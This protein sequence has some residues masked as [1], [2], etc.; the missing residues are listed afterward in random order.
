MS[1]PDPTRPAA[2]PRA[3]AFAPGDRF[4][5][6]EVR[7]FLGEGGSGEVY[8][9]ENPHLG[10]AYAL[11]IMRLA[12]REDPRKVARALVEGKGASTVEHANV[13]RVFDLGCEPDGRVWI[14]M[15]RLEGE[16]L[17]ERLA[18]QQRL[19]PL[20]ALRV[21]IDAAWGLDAAHE[22]QILHRD[23]KPDN[24]FLTRAG[25]VK[26]LDFSIAKVIPEG[27]QTTLGKVGLG[28][29]GYMA[30]ERFRGAR[31]DARLDV[32]A[33]GITLWQ[34]LAGRHPFHEALGDL[35]AMIEKQLRVLPAPLAGELGLPAYVDEVIA[36]AVAKDPAARFL[37]MA[38]MAQALLGVRERLARDA[39]EKR[40]VLP[41]PPEGE[42]KL[43]DDAPTQRAYRAPAP[44]PRPHTQPDR[45][46]ARVVVPDR[47]PAA[48]PPAAS[49]AAPLGPRLFALR[50]PSTPL[51][52]AA[53]LA[54]TPPL[55]ETEERGPRGTVLL[56]RET[57]AALAAPIPARESATI[58]APAP[59]ERRP[60][61]AGAR[62]PATLAIAAGAAI[63]VAS[64]VI[65]SRA[66]GA[67]SAAPT[68]SSPAPT[69]LED[70]GAPE[71]P[72][73]APATATSAASSA[74]TP[75]KKP[76]SAIPPKPPQ[77]PA[78]RTPPTTDAP[79]PAPAPAPAVVDIY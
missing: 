42:P 19:S 40:I 15:E 59:T 27:L 13:V 73:P 1:P 64:A 22:A 20:F 3:R 5:H 77:K 55:P 61:R 41:A 16:S 46:G 25:V 39:Q 14:L 35:Q 49:T 38:E 56:P 29:P 69:W 79:R 34:L 67:R 43:P 30:P 78:P 68:E 8:E 51:P 23:V 44:A 36:R 60:R 32:Y 4:H 58:A 72:T 11:K 65:A 66:G 2:P 48:P 74:P 50:P 37:T 70:A 26:V 24:L 18:H 31:P 6:Y 17:A 71:P 12:D 9:V 76:S 33:L 53:P 7:R 52:E 63:L 28:S 21:A 54:A 57:P 62:L 10:R 47:A 75:P 45:R